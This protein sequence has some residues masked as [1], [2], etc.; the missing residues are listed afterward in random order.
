MHSYIVHT[1]ILPFVK[2]KRNKRVSSVILE[3]ETLFVIS[4][5]RAQSQIFKPITKIHAA[6]NTTLNDNCNVWKFEVIK[7]KPSCSKEHMGTLCVSK[8]VWVN[9]EPPSLLRQFTKK[10]NTKGYTGR[11]ITTS[12]YLIISDT[13]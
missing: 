7:V 13:E 4:S 12:V 3:I 2:L 1:Y 11:S 8:C 9:H 10:L 6:S 5:K